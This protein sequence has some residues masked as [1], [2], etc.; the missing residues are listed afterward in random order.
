MGNLAMLSFPIEG[1]VP[2]FRTRI[3][4]LAVFRLGKLK[5]IPRM[6]SWGF[7]GFLTQRQGPLDFEV[8][9][10]SGIFWLVSERLTRRLPFTAFRLTAKLAPAKIAQQKF[11]LELF[12]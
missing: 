2:G 10:K 7:Y 8:R 4:V 1:G 6:R 3:S 11:T 9:Y 5:G 12:P